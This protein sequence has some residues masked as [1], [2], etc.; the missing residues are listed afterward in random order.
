MR[1]GPLLLVLLLA[2]CGHT[3]SDVAALQPGVDVA[4]AALRGGSPQTA[5]QLA[6]TVLAQHPGNEAALGVQGDALTEMGRLDEARDSY[7]R[8]LQSND[9][10]VGAEVGLGRISLAVDPAAASLLFLRA[11]HNDP[12]N[13]AALNDLGVA[14]DLQGDHAG[15]Q[16]EYRQALGIDPQD[17]AAQVNLALSMAMSGAAADAVRMLRPMASDP[18]ASRKL[19]HDLAAALTMAGDRDEATRILSKDLSPDDVRQA[20]DDYAAARSGRS[21]ALLAGTGGSAAAVALTPGPAPTSALPPAATAAAQPAATPASPPA[22]TPASPAESTPASPL[23]SAPAPAPTGGTY[24]QLAA[25]P[26]DGAARSEWRRMERKMPAL[27]SDRHPIFNRKVTRNG[28][29]IWLVRT[30][31]FAD[32]AQAKAFCQQVRTAGGSCFVDAP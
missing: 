20:L 11:L 4:Q 32:E 2:A 7:N 8:A 25:V 6:G 9:A 14:R 18:N 19:R 5:L 3:Q 21:A 10:S 27:V 15:A 13:T 30:G 31:G 26:S 17:S 24:V 1:G 29:A 28:H 22:A 12:R 23:A 16:Q